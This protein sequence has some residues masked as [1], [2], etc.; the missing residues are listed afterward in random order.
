MK[1]NLSEPLKELRELD[2]NFPEITVAVRTSDTSSSEKQKMLRKP[3]HILITTP[4]SF[5][6]SLTSLKF[7]EKLATAEWIVIDEIHELASSKRG[8]LLMSS[9]E[10][11]E[12][13]IKGSSITRVGLSATI[14]PLEEV[15]KFLTGPG[16]QCKIVDA[17]FVKPIDIRVISPVKDL[18]HATEDEVEQ[19]IYRYLTEEIKRHRTTLVFTN[20]RSGTERVS[21]KLRK[22]LSSEQLYDADLVAAH[23]SSLS[24]EVRLDVEERLKRGELKVVVSSTSLE[25]GIDIGY[26]DLV[27]LLSSPKSVSR[28]LQRIGRAGHHIKAV[29]EGRI[30]VVDRD[31]LVECSVLAQLARERKIDSVHIPKKPLDVLVQVILAASLIKEVEATELFEILK[32]TYT[33]HDLTFEEFKGVL[34]YLTG[35][36][37]LEENKVYAKVRLREGKV[38]P[39]FGSRMIFMLNSGTIPDEAKVP[40]R[41]ENGRYIGNLEEEFAEILSPGDIFVLAGKTYEFVGSRSGEVIVRPAEG[42]RP[43]VP[44]WFSEMLPLAYDSARE[45]AKFRGEVA[46]L[47]KQGRSR[48]EIVEYIQRRLTLNKREAESIYVYVLEQYLFTGG[49][50]PSD[51]LYLV[52]ILDEEDGKR[53]FIY[54]VLIGRRA[55]DALSRAFAYKVSNDLNMDVKIS[56]TDNGF[57]LT[58]PERVD[59]DPVKPFYELDPEGL[60]DVLSQVLLRTELLKRRFR[61]V[62]ERAFMIL[63]RYR[64]KE[65]SLERR[66]LS[67]ET[68]LEVVKKIE[69]FPVLKET[70]REILEDYMDYRRAAETLRRVQS[71]EVKVVKFGP[72]DTP[73]PF[74]H[75]ILIKEYSDVVLAADKRNLLRDLHEKVVEYLKK[76]GIDV[77]L[78]ETTV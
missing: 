59:Y 52:E 18:V 75:N 38:V 8:S 12:A 65:K 53:T 34:D 76:K 46:D 62:A 20:T 49:I 50:V 44:S 78:L 73:S 32:R 58:L 10:M 66:Q 2:E 5:T 22:V 64:G 3:P 68:L 51:N 43:T 29:S 74:A 35:K 37:G 63:K 69:D 70:F 47:I 16:R 9:V 67:S 1:R 54:H 27:V 15:A 55:L 48:G 19:G 39:K 23:H 57:A 42:Q 21:Y 77:N 60:Y 4:E 41:L 6:I 24:R 25:L 45:I 30:I 28:L 61:H 56:L 33:Y 40:V 17:R 72:T 36:Y 26:I 7:R 11:L 71:G 31:D 13:L 14:S